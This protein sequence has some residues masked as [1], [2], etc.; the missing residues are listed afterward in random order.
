[1]V[2]AIVGQGSDSPK[3]LFSKLFN[4]SG[5][6]NVLQR[7]GS[8]MACRRGGALG[9]VDLCMAKALLEEVTINLTTELAQD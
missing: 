1:M 5:E 6:W 9:A 2:T 3:V 7:Y 8:A 4:N